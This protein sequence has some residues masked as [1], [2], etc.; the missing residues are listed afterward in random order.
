MFFDEYEYGSWFYFID[1]TQN[2]S[3]SLCSILL[4]QRK[5]SPSHSGFQIFKDPPVYY[6]LRVPR[7]L[8]LLGTEE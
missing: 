8:V 1:E 5:F 7:P 6:D 2:S 4:Y 3:V